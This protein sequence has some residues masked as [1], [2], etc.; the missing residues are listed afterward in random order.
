[1]VVVWT[2]ARGKFVRKFVRRN[3]TPP[4]GLQHYY[5]VEAALQSRVRFSLCEHGTVLAWDSLT[6]ASR[7]VFYDMKLVRTPPPIIGR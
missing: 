7:S 5:I 1:M 6:R 3:T 4:I 2:V